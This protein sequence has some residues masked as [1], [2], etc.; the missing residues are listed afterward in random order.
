MLRLCIAA[1]VFLSHFLRPVVVVIVLV[2]IVA[3]VVAMTIVDNI[4][5]GENSA[6]TRLSAG[7]FSAS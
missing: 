1:S 5:I 2:I 4:R 3:A 7:S 6:C